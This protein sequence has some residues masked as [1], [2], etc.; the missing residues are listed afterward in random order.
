MMYAKAVTLVIM[1]TIM[2]RMVCEADGHDAVDSN[3]VVMPPTHSSSLYSS[4][5]SP[6]SQAQRQAQEASSTMEPTTS[7]AVM[8]DPPVDG[9]DAADDTEAEAEV[10]DDA[11]A[12]DADDADAVD[13]DTADADDADGAVMMDPPVSNST[14]NDTDA[15]EGPATGDMVDVVVPVQDSYDYT[16][17][18]DFLNGQWPAMTETCARKKHK[19]NSLT[20]KRV[21]KVGVQ[22]TSGVERAW[23][24]YNTTFLTYLNAVVGP[25]FDPPIRFEMEVTTSPLKDWVSCAEKRSVFSRSPSVWTGA[26]K[27]GYVLSCRTFVK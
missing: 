26:T 21:Y 23:R 19:F 2:G 27:H 20:Q 15:P 9:Q 1:G 7:E 11:E 4:Y 5:T 24:D 18:Q 3:V 10:V 16:N 13:A 22:A 25:R 12:V 6:S 14:S 17:Y 8:M